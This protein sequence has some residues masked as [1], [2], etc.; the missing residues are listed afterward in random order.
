MELAQLEAVLHA[1][2]TFRDRVRR[3]HGEEGLAQAYKGLGLEA[4]ASDRE[5]KLAYRRLM[6]RH[7]PDKLSARG[8]PDAMLEVA[9]EKTSEI[10]KAYDV[11]KAR[12]G[13]K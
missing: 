2:R 10:G 5:V 8:L 12:R 4:S 9:K 6:N 11:I 1:Q 13:L 7:H 3:T